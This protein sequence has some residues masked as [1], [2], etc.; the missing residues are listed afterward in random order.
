MAEALENMPDRQQP[1]VAMVQ[2]MS[3]LSAPPTSWTELLAGIAVFAD[4]LLL[5][6]DGILAGWEPEQLVW[7]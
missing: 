2:R 5:D 6:T 1:Y 7:K 3:Y 4:P